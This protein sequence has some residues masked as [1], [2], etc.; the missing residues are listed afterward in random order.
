MSTQSCNMGCTLHVPP[1]RRYSALPRQLAGQGGG[2]QPGAALGGPQ[3]EDKVR[4]SYWARS[5]KINL[6][7]NLANSLDQILKQVVNAAI[8]KK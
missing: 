8:L 2:G 3:G 5:C 1:S 7:G 4:L 6:G